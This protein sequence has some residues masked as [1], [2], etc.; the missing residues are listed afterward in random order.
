MFRALQFAW[1]TTPLVLDERR[2]TRDRAAPG[3][4]ARRRRRD[5]PARR[6][7][8]DRGVRADRAEARTAA[9]SATELQGKAAMTDGPVRY[10]APVADL[11][12]GGAR[13]EAGGF[14]TI[15][16][17]DVLSRTSTR[18]SSARTPPDDL[19]ARARALPRRPHDPGGR[20]GDGAG[21]P[22]A[23][24]RRCRGGADRARRERRAA[25][26]RRSATTR[27]GARAPPRRRPRQ[28]PRAAWIRS[29]KSRDARRGAAQRRV[30]RRSSRPSPR[31][32]GS[33]G[34]SDE[35][36]AGFAALRG[37]ARRCRS[38][39]RRASTSDD[40]D[41]DLARRTA[42]ML[43][44]AGL[45]GHHRRRARASWRRPTAARARRARRR[46]A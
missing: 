37:S 41:Y 23:G 6:P 14:Q 34:S 15:E 36:D 19:G 28:L 40:P 26:G 25:P 17:Y 27:C 18:R 4:G 22:G 13:L 9:G 3:A 29:A 39:A 35:L 31:R 10:T 7:R 30:A 16:A 44:E 1:F 33:T 43:G 12:R 46:S 2:R 11:H 45:R 5:R 8:R 24:P 21:E 20:G 32:S 38:S 42:R